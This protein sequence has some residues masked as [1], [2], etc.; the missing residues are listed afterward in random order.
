MSIIDVFSTASIKQ[1]GMGVSDILLFNDCIGNVGIS[2]FIESGS[3]PAKIEYTYDTTDIIETED[4]AIINWFDWYPSEV[5]INTSRY[6][7]CPR[8]M[9][10]NVPSSGTGTWRLCVKGMKGA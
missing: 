10:I 6:D 8:A 7:V 5:S 1:D 3:G 2:F 9:R 4:D